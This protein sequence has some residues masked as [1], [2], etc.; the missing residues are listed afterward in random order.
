MYILYLVPET[1]EAR[2]NYMAAANAYESKPYGERDAGFDLYSAAG[3]V[4][5]S[6]PTRLSQQ[7]IAAFYDDARGH[8]RAFYMLPR[9]SFPH[10]LRLTN[11][12]GL[13]DAGYRGLI[14]ASLVGS[15]E[16][17]EN[18]RIVQLATPDLLP[19]DRVI[20]VDAIPGGPTARGTGVFGS[21]GAGAISGEPVMSY[22]T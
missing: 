17:E 9:S 8:F 20:V 13:I 10:T 3:T 12:V 16:I 14:R 15:A 19:W 11:G 7:V 22:F 4:S 21:T 1:T 2:E 6:A 18:R 5:E